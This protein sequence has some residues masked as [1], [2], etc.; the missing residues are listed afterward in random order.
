MKYWWNI[1]HSSLELSQLNKVPTSSLNLNNKL[2][3]SK[4]QTADTTIVSS[5]NSVRKL[6]WVAEGS[7][8]RTE[9]VMNTTKSDKNLTA[10]WKRDGAGTKA[11]A[12]NGIEWNL[13]Q[14]ATFSS[15]KT[16]NTSFFNQ[17]E[18][19]CNTFTLVTTKEENGNKLWDAEF[20]KIVI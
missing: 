6:W 1:F 9:T 12:T 18:I 13:L 8:F 16:N 20:Q 19:P 11:A 2:L 5:E 4:V 17:M 10:Y 15:T 14:M 3:S 7:Q